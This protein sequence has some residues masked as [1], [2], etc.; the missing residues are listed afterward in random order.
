MRKQKERKPREPRQSPWRILRNNAVLFFKVFRYTPMYIIGS[1]LIEGVVQGLANA[2]GGVYM[3]YLFNALD[4][5]R[6]FEYVLTIVALWALWSTFY[7]LVS[8]FYHRYFKNA[9]LYKLNHKLHGELFMKTK[10]MDVSCY[11]DPEFYNDFVWAMDEAGDRSKK[12]V[13]SLNSLAAR[14]IALITILGTMIAAELDTV[15]VIGVVVLGIVGCVI[16]CLGNKLGYAQEKERKPLS[17]K[18]S[19]LN[20]VY[21]L[22][23]YAKELRLGHADELLLREADENSEQKVKLAKK[24]G[25]KYFFLYGLCNNVLIETSSLVITF[26]MFTRLLEGAVLVGVFAASVNLI[27][28]VRWNIYDFVQKLAKFPEHSLFLEKYYGFLEYEPKVVGGGEE[29]PE[30]ESLEL[31]NVSFTYDF[32]NNPKY[33]WHKSDHKKPVNENARSADALKEVDLK[34]EKGEKIAIVG[35]NGAGKTTLIKL[36]MRLYDPT[37][38]EILYN[39]RAAS[40]YDLP[41]YREKIGCVFQDFKI[42]SSTIAENVMAGAYDA[43]RDAENVERSLDAVGFVDKLNSLELGT[44][45]MLTR[46]FDKKGTNLSGGESQKVAIARVF[47][48][49]Y[50]LWIMDEPSS[51]LDPVAE[52]ELNQSIL[53]YAEGKTVIFISHRLSTTRMADRI[54]MFDSG[55]LIEVGSHEQLMEMKGKYAEMFNLQAEKYLEE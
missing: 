36:L 47:A 46:E 26:Y 19:Y 10:S 9:L 27:W 11:D 32:S 6:P 42:F 45:T 30:F 41:K 22:P 5:G 13:E 39:G 49:P 8:R 40:V 4:E 21:H 31:K 12:I 7:Q 55:R 37:E 23:D 17:R 15:I 14:L 38:G 33:R 43:E 54:Y 16:F 18:Q 35:Y 50:E 24:Y 34:I 3:L 53:K 44:A 1:F 29:V 48:R 20:R 51:A 52:Y 25:L 2:A 28:H